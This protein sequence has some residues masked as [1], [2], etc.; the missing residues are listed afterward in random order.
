MYA[1]DLNMVVIAGTDAA[2]EGMAQKLCD[3]VD[4]WAAPTRLGVSGAKSSVMVVSRAGQGS[5][6]RRSV[7]GWEPDITIGGNR[8][9]VVGEQ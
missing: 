9:S 6:W 1:D 4:D 7:R 2:A 8:L 5:G 3:E